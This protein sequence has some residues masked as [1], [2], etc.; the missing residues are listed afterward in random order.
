[1]ENNTGNSK[2]EVEQEA[3]KYLN[4]TRKWVMF[5]A[6]FGFIILGL[7][8]IIGLIA[9]TFMS[10]FSGGKSESLFSGPM[11]FGAVVF[12]AVTCFF[13]G[14][15]LFRF[16]KHIHR[17]LESYDKLELRKA[18]KNLRSYFVYIGILIILFLGAYI[19]AIVITGSSM[20]FLKGIS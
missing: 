6:V 7:I 2:I 10:A 9:G 13:P 11:I 19:A 20:S 3:L 14:L 5:L 16:S 4:T 15:Y 17:A 18:F 8:I 1:M 12:A